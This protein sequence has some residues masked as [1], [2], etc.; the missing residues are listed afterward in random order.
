MF[1]PR[2]GNRFRVQLRSGESLE[3]ELVAA[4]PLI[5]RAETRNDQP[6]APFSLTFLGPEGVG[7]PQQTVHIADADYGEFDLFVVPIA[8]DGDRLILEAIFN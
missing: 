3:F 4:N 7:F 5:E 2:V 1:E 6:R 8:R